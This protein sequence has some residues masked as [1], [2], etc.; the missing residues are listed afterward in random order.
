MI[1]HCIFWHN[2][3]RACF[4]L[5]L[6]FEKIQ[7]RL[8]MYLLSAFFILLKFQKNLIMFKS[9]IKWFN[10]FFSLIVIFLIYSFLLFLFP[11]DIV[12]FLMTLFFDFL[13]FR[14]ILII[15]SCSF[16]YIFFISLIIFLFSIFLGEWLSIILLKKKFNV[17]L[18]LGNKFV[19]KIFALPRAIM[20]CLY[21]IKFFL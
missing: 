14:K 5:F 13:I 1:S 4:L 10:K 15:L 6:L 20:D 9:L 11:S 21:S 12:L 18:K 2:F 7:K 16:W 17:F 3:F 19:Y 8:F